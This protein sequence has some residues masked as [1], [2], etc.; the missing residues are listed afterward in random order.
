MYEFVGIAV[1]V[2]SPSGEGSGSSTGSPMVFRVTR[3]RPSGA[4]WNVNDMGNSDKG[5]SAKK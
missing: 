5:G 2:C 3:G 1:A 4:A